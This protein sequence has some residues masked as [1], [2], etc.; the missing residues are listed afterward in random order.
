MKQDSRWELSADVEA[1]FSAYDEPIR[2][3][4]LSLR[5]LIFD[6]ALA[7]EGV[8]PLQETLK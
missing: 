2:Q 6:T 8:W 1:V 5:Q 3:S 7:T 4:L